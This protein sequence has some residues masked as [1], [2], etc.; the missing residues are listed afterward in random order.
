MIKRVV[1]R[2]YRVFKDFT[3]S[4]NTGMNIIVGDNETG[5]STLLEAIALGL[6]GR[7]NGRWA[8]EELNP[9]WFHQA[10]VSEFF[11]KYGTADSI[12]PPEI[13]IELYLQSDE[14]DVQ[15]MRGAINSLQ[16]DCPG[17]RIY[18]RPDENYAGEFAEY[19]SADHPGVL[20]T[21]FYDVVWRD[22]NDMPIRRRPKELGVS[23]IDSR[24]VRSSAGVDHHTRQILGSFLDTKERAQ[25]AVAHRQARHKI[26]TEA[27]GSLNE[28]MAK[29]SEDLH[30]SAIGLAMDQSA[31]ASW[32]SGVV[33]QVAEIP[34]AMI[35]QG[36]QAAIKVALAMRR[37]ADSARFVLIEEPET[38]LSYSRLQRLVSRI[39]K[40]AGAE[41][42]I[43]VTTHSSYV[44][45]RLGIDNLLL[46]TE[47]GTVG[48]TDLS[49]DTVAYFKHLS[50]YDTLRLVLANK[51][52]LVEGPSDEMIF[53]RAYH[54]AVGRYPQD[55][56]ID[57]VSM[58]GVTFGRAL[59]LC[60]KLERSAV[61]LQDN[62][63][64][65]PDEIL[66]DL[67]EHLSPD[68]RVYIGDPALGTTL[69]PQLITANGVER[70]KQVLNLRQQDDP[71]TWMPNHKTE[72]ALR[73]LESYQSICFPPYIRDAVESFR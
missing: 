18:I 14:S 2:G 8:T 51:L 9:F 45:N 30:E 48:I 69:E 58:S 35:G 28:Q 42:Q 13:E 37:R 11:A 6:T 20:P 70:L 16:E 46:L 61:A 72:A 34:F 57:V 49:P 62:D 31:R 3:V 15:R 19:M 59:E 44:L 22:F 55:D 50:G 47:S 52:A 1:I 4:P 71:T 73:I 12:K 39:E 38:H 10:N 60:A 17:T 25:I 64:R 56:G 41:Q 40:L 65:N 43:F 54:D 5:K 32:E 67:E 68:R 24:T 7:V 29:D 27:L 36:Q 21:E 33:P 53:I 66:A 26:T 23:F 63:G